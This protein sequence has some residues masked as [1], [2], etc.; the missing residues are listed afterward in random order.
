MIRRFTI[1]GFKR[2]ERE[3]VIEIDPV[4]V[5]V[6][7]NNSGKS[8]VLDALT[9]FQY[10]VETTRR[11]ANGNGSGNGNGRGT[12]PG[13]GN[14]ARIDLAERMVGTDEF[15]VLP[16]AKPTDLW[17]GGRTA[18]GKKQQT[19]ELRAEYDNGAEI[20]FALKRYF[21]SFSI[22]PSAGGD[23]TG[24]VR[25]WGIRPI[26]I[27]SAFLPREEYLTFPERRER[28]RMQRHGEVVRNLLWEL[29]EHDEARWNTLVELL[30]DL[31]PESGLRVAFD[32]GIDRFI[33]AAYSDRALTRELDV[34]VSGSGFHQA[35]QL[36]VSVLAPGARVLV[37]YGPRVR[38]TPGARVLL[39]DEPDT[40][41]HARLHEQFMAIMA[42][43]ARDERCQFI[44]AT[45][46]PQLLSAA[47]DGSV[48]VCKEGTVVPLDL[49]SGQLRLLEDLGAMDRMEIVPLLTNRA[50][51]FVENRS[52]RALLEAFARRHW[53]ER[54]QREVWRALT[55][56]YT[57]QGPAEARVLDLARQ[58][59]ELL[60]GSGIAG[61]PVRMVAIGD[62]DYRT[63]ASR[64]RELRSLAKR[65]QSE[66][67]RL[68]LTVRLWEANEIEN[69]LL[70]GDAL[71]GALDRQAV[72]K[73]RAQEWRGRREAFLD[74]LRS[75]VDGQRERVR[76]AVATRIQNED[77]RLALS[78]V[79]DRADAFLG[80][81]WEEPMRWC[82]AKEVFRKLRTWLQ[83]QGLPLHIVESEVIDA[84]AAVPADV[85]KVLRELQRIAN[86]R[87]GRRTA[88][89]ARA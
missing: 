62:R 71:A 51:V 33:T 56:L 60:A 35:L 43:L 18:I 24:A 2:F 15:G 45:H 75:L 9:L 4:T 65:A 50:L 22:T 31:F 81:Q 73:G 16:V 40:H 47:P 7:V 5:L 38:L 64:R 37:P 13:N 23:V 41:L 89:A 27:F 53:G 14:G 54:K 78:T 84:M 79:L 66:A 88:R 52:D 57:Y 76:Q 80:N 28:M 49:G 1:K 83:E 20:A 74:E 85:Q 42:R 17:P 61:Q 67:Y 32:A 86:P 29:R 25:D 12:G 36:L 77:R 6:G 82:D 70:D 44:L 19:I 87:A 46:S 48:R 68:D 55:F 39:L 8:T 58:V 21:N 72:A 34:V 63:D 69:Y 10:C 3:T 59:N 11:A 30:R 26:P